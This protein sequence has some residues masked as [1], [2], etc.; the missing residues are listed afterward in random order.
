MRR[1]Q[2]ALVSQGASRLT[3]WRPS[4][5]RGRVQVVEFVT[6]KKYLQRKLGPPHP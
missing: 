2:F 5:G 3:R 4:A 6:S 1:P